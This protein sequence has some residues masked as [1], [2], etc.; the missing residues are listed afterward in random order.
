MGSGRLEFPK[1]AQGKGEIERYKT[2]NPK[3][4]FFAGV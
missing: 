1:D 2:L 3:H 4:G